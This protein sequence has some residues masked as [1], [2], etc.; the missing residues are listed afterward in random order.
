[1][2]LNLIVR[3]LIIYILVLISGCS[4]TNEI[5]TYV[6]VKSNSDE[7]VVSEW[8]PVMRVIYRVG[9]KSVISEV[10]GLLDEYQNCAIENKSNWHCEY[11][12]GT[13]HN[14]FGFKKGVFW[15]EPGW[16]GE[17]DHVSRWDFNVIRCK[18][19]QYEKGKFDGIKTCL[20]TF[21]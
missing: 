8:R 21:V 14:K 4:N 15:Q 6:V 11:E 19:Y 16:D 10:A 3:L 12:D 18:W 5:Y 17:I 7:K 2:K 20:K 9:E 1:M 13:G